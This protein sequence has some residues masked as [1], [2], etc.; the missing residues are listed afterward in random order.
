VG[1][2]KVF[3]ISHISKHSFPSFYPFT[4][5]PKSTIMQNFMEVHDWP[6]FETIVNRLLRSTTAIYI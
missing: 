4:Q 1:F 5:V 2:Q 3:N 6:F